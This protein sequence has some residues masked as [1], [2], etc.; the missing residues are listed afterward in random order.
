MLLS[1][2]ETEEVYNVFVVNKEIHYAFC[3]V[4]TVKATILK[5]YTNILQRARVTYPVLV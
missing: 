3:E 1:T 2:P 5:L 4:C